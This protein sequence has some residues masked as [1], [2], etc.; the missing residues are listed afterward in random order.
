MASVSARQDIQQHI[1]LIGDIS[2]KTPL[3]YQMTC[4]TVQLVTVIRA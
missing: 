2:F 3:A 1:P 4:A